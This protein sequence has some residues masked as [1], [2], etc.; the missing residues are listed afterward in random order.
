MVFL[1]CHP[2]PQPSLIIPERRK[3]RLPGPA[4]EL[5]VFFSVVFLIAVYELGQLHPPHGVPGGA[6]AD[7]EP[8]VLARVQLEAE[9]L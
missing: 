5:D 4:Q 8:D 3:Q 1:F 7:D 6:V 2:L 9:P